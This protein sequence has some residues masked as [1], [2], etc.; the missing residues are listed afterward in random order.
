MEI[1][2]VVISRNMLNECILS[3]ENK[4][5]F[6][7]HKTTGAKFQTFMDCCCASLSS[8]Q[9]GSRN[10]SFKIVYQ[11]FIITYFKIILTKIMEH[12]LF[13]FVLH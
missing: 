12:K 5:R 2:W 13:L 4:I 1:N 3:I 8:V 6:E 11:A 7:Q 9:Y 10:S